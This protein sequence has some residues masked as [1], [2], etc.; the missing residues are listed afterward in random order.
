MYLSSQVCTN[1]IVSFIW[2]TMLLFGMPEAEECVLAPFAVDMDTTLNDGRV[3]YRQ[4]TEPWI[5]VRA[6]RD[7]RRSFPGARS[8]TA[9]WVLIA[10]YHKVT[11]VGGDKT[12]PV[13]DPVYDLRF[14]VDVNENHSISVKTPATVLHIMTLYQTS[15]SL[16][17]SYFFLLILCLLGYS[18]QSSRLQHVY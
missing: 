6:T 16:L 1:G 15:S 18:G 14:S 4:T 17:L 5:R 11:F 7:V 13:R 8:F 12:S 2:D 3:Y 9:K 10:S